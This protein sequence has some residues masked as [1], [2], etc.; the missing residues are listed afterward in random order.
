MFMREV[1]TDKKRKN[2]YRRLS[3][4]VGSSFFGKK[5][6]VPFFYR[7]AS[8]V[9][10]PPRLIPISI[11]R[12]CSKGRDKR[13]AFRFGEIFYGFSFFFLWYCYVGKRGEYRCWSLLGHFGR[14]LHR[15]IPRK[16]NRHCPSRKM[17]FDFVCI[18][19][20]IYDTRTQFPHI[21]LPLIFAEWPKNITFNRHFQ[22]NISFFRYKSEYFDFFQVGSRRPTPSTQSK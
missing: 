1:S 19:R 8:V 10:S 12:F 17:L 6:P 5:W 15:C 13:C 20:T 2:Q 7:I 18:V 11:G 4:L 9:P 14:R 21:F 22:H 16:K 3:S